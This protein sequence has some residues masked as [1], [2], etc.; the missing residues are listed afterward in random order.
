MTMEKFHKICISCPAGCHLDITRD[1]ENISVSG[2][3]CPRGVKYAQQELTDPRRIV[4]AVVFAAGD[5]RIC[6]PVKSS[7]PVPM[8]LI[9]EL[10][11]ELYSLRIPLPVGIG[12]VILKDFRST[13]IDV[14]ASS[15]CR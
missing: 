3:N 8:K 13:G 10:L 15:E 9:P 5:K 1:G 12:E 14:V 7:A 2:N 6:I 4:T 11:K